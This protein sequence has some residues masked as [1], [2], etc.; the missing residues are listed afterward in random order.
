MHLRRLKDVARKT[1]FSRCIW[2]V[3]KNTSFLRCL[4]QRRPDWDVSCR[5]GCEYSLRWSEIWQQSLRCKRHFFH[6]K[7]HLIW[8]EI[9]IQ[10]GRLEHS[11]AEILWIWEFLAIFAEKTYLEPPLLPPLIKIGTRFSKS[12][13]KW[14]G[15]WDFL[16]KWGEGG[17]NK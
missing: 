17:L 6:Q 14:E 15:M 10:S 5:L 16:Q 13:K 2:D 9:L 12:G 11:Q 3:S 1:S 4:F 8:H 7:S